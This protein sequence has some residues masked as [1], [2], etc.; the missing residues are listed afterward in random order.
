[1]KRLQGNLKLLEK[2]YR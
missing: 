2:K 1:M